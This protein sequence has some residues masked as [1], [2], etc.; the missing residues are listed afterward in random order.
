MD[1]IRVDAVIFGGGGVGLWILS[2]LVEKGYHA[3]LL[4]KDKLG[5]GQT[6]SSQGIIHGGLKYSLGG[7]ITTSA[8][9]IRDMPLVWNQCLAGERMP[10]LTKVKIL[11]EYCYYW[12]APTITS[13]I[14]QMVAKSALKA[15]PIS[16]SKE[17]RPIFLR[18]C[19]GELF[20]TKERVINTASFIENLFHT[21]KDWILH[22]DP[23]YLEVIKK[24]K[25]EISISNKLIII[26]QYVIFAAGKGNNELRKQFGIKADKMQLRPLHMVMVKGKLPMLFGHCIEGNSTRIT[27]TSMNY[28]D[29]TVWQVGGN[30]AEKGVRME[31]DELIEKAYEELALL[32]PDIDFS[33]SEFSSYM[34]DRAENKTLSGGRPARP[35]VVQKDNIITVWPIKLA[36]FPLSAYL[37]SDLIDKPSTDI[38]NKEQIINLLNQH[39]KP[40]IA[41]FPWE[42]NRIWRKVK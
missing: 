40:S 37:T 3:I 7:R 24:P 41:K 16:V 22:Y 28:D 25:T 4:E 42:T 29:F 11:S 38:I 8:K 27:V 6:I 39:E 30:L 14:S 34:V 9:E 10:N 12:Q 35:Y 21:Y 36:F 2:E 1:K 13:K 19:P 26:P 20:K 23:S 5:E 17:Q 33:S 32:L 18:S 31:Q 15:S